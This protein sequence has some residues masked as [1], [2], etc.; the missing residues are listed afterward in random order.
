[1]LSRTLSCRAC[2]LLRSGQGLHLSPEPEYAVTHH[3]AT[4]RWLSSGPHRASS[5]VS[6]LDEYFFSGP[7]DHYISILKEK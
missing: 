6:S 3:Q 7:A 2:T 1:M 5:Y 4:G